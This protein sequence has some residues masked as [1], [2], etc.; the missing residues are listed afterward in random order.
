[1]I[2]RRRKAAVQ[3]D[4]DE[5]GFRRWLRAHR[6]P[7]QWFLALPVDQQEA[8]A[9]IGD[10]FAVRA[11]LDIGY[12]V[13]DPQIAEAGVKAAGGDAE[14]EESLAIRLARSFA[15]SIQRREEA[16]RAT[17][18][19]PA[20]GL[21]GFGARRVSEILPSHRRSR[22]LFGKTPDPKGGA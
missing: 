12:A 18:S 20:S 19:E 6:P 8:M 17:P 11:A 13:K 5:G 2:F 10:E 9:A 7:L 14:A 3:V 15:E 4:L 16:P 1:M 21:A 22:T